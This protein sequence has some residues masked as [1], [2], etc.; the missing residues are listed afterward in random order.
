MASGSIKMNGLKATL[1]ATSQ[2]VTTTEKTLS[3][4]ARNYKGIMF[5]VHNGGSP[6]TATWVGQAILPSNVG[7]LHTTGIAL[8][9]MNSAFDVRI[10]APTLTSC[11]YY[12]VGST[13]LSP[14]ISVYGLS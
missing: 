6:I 12:L 11:S 3:Y 10:Y 13:Q 2:A 14:Y 1:L 8:T 7:S 5:V 9:N 4:D